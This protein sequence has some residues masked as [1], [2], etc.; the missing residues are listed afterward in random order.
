MNIISID[1][2]RVS[3]ASWPRDGVDT[4]RVEYFVAALSEGEELPPIGVTYYSSG[5]Y[6]ICDGVHRVVAAREFG[7]H[8]IPVVEHQ[9]MLDGWPA[10]TRG[11]FE[12]TVTTALDRFLTSRSN[13]LKQLTP[14][15]QRRAALYFLWLAP[16][17]DRQEIAHL[18]GCTQTEVEEWSIGADGLPVAPEQRSEG[19]LRLAPLSRPIVHLT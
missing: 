9:E 3:P 7:L 15:E 8:D 14:S 4:S 1:E 18:V 2:V 16:H 10:G 17:F 5:M 12:C 11:L 19:L 13:W 6:F